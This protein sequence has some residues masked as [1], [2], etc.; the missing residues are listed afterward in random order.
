MRHLAAGLTAIAM[1]FL[2][3]FLLGM[4]EGPPL[5][6]VDWQALDP[7]LLP[8]WVQAGAVCV[9]AGLAFRFAAKRREG[10]I[11]RSRKALAARART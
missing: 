8:A 2:A 4:V 7:T 5:A 3:D 10:A 6:A 1:F 9:M 11:T